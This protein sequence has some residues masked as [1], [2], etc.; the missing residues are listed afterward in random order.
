MRRIGVSQALT[1][2]FPS[3]SA[4]CVAACIIMSGIA[5]TSAWAQGRGAC[6]GGG[7]GH[8]RVAPRVDAV[9]VYERCLGGDRLAAITLWRASGA[10]WDAAPDSVAFDQRGRALVVR[11]HDGPH[12]LSLGR[13]DSVLVVM[14]DWVDAVAGPIPVTTTRLGAASAAGLVPRVSDMR[15]AERQGSR[16]PTLDVSNQLRTLLLR[17]GRS[18]RFIGE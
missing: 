16:A 2:A 17:D 6:L 9:F 3:R 10:G 7:T 11:A 15:D 12:P 18:R 4:M 5:A 8:A 14:L 13:T 1:H